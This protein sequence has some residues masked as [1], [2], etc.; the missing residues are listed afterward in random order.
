MRSGYGRHW[1]GYILNSRHKGV[2]LGKQIAQCLHDFSAHAHMFHILHRNCTVQGCKQEFAKG[3]PWHR[4]M[5]SI[6][7]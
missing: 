6:G 5:P 7:A 4:R 3:L 1:I 2:P